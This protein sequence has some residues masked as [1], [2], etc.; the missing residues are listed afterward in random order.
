MKRK[1]KL[2]CTIM[3]LICFVIGGCANQADGEK[4]IIKVG[5]NA[6]FPPFEYINDEGE[7]DGFDMAIMRAIGEEM[8]YE[9]KGFDAYTSSNVLKGSGLSSSAAFEVLIGNI[10]NGLF[11]NN[12]VSDVEIA[13]IGQYAENVYFGKPC[14]LMDQMASSV[15]AVVS[16]DFKDLENPLIKKVDFDFS[17]SGY[18]LCIIDS[19]ADHADLTDEY[20][21]IPYEMKKVAQVFEKEVLREVDETLFMENIALVREKCGDRAVLRAMH[22]YADNNRAILEAEALKK[23]DFKRF[24]EV[25]TE[26]GRSSYM[27]LQNV[28]VCGSSNHQAVALVLALCDKIL[29]NI[30][31]L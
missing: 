20:A 24:L 9:I 21:S 18:A 31:I 28:S 4:K 7:V 27:Y 1:A 29:K 5:T 10:L 23:G 6:E 3:L 15:G 22:F 19:G 25:V 16:I 12:S 17:K 2:I 14:G 26:S 11:A 13:K 8:G 30:T